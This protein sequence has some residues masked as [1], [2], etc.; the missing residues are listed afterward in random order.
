MAPNNAIRPLVR[1]ARQATRTSPAA[2]SLSSLPA[3]RP[4]T[5]Q[6]QPQPRQPNLT[7]QPL[8]QPTALHPQHRHA[9][10]TTPSTPLKQTPLHALHAAANAKLVAFASYAMPLTYP[11]LTPSESHHWT[12]THASLFDVSHMVQH[13]LSGPLA[14]RF[15]ETITPS[16]LANLPKY[17]ST[18]SCLLSEN[19]GIV[20]DTVITRVGDSAFYFVTNA[21]C[22]EGDLAFIEAELGKFLEREGKNGGEGNEKLVNWQ[23]LERHALLA[24]QGPKAVD[25]L[26]PLVFRDEDDDQLGEFFVLNSGS[27]AKITRMDVDLVAPFCDAMPLYVLSAAHSVLTESVRPIYRHRPLNT[28]LRPVPLAPALDPER[29]HG[30]RHS[31]VDTISSDLPYRY[32]IASSASLFPGQSST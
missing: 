19:G 7:P 3:R 5:A 22:R 13:K 10:T 2:R 11:S 6:E 16:A 26:Q 18:L 30:R 27:Y 15:L 8:N 23:V 12:R 20:D 17:T 28:L 21:G 32:A 9:S 25:V 1:A 24:L 4:S 31:S 29:V 14:A